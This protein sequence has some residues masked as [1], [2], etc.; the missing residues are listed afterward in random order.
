LFARIAN[1][2]WDAS[3]TFHI[4]N[5]KFVPIQGFTF[6]EEMDVR[7]FGIGL[8]LASWSNRMPVTIPCVC[9]GK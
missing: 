8:D 3:K 7:E 6:E 4:R 9:A 5:L 1:E 2:G